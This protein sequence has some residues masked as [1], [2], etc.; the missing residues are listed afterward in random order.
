ML[1][2][3]VGDYL[4][5]IY[6]LQGDGAVSTTDIARAL[7]VSSASVTNMIK[8]LAQMKMVEYESYKGVHLTEAGERIALEIIRHHRLLETYLKEMLGYSWAGMHEEAER[9]EHHISEEFEDKIDALLGHPTH[10]PHG[11]PI[12][13]RDLQITRTATTPLTHAEP[14]QPLVIHHVSDGDAELL[15]YLE[16]IGL[17]PQKTIEI[18]EKAP[19]KG[20]LTLRIGDREQVVGHEVASNV[21]VTES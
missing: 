3:A 12:P 1:S 6:K 7:E 16:E 10:D 14:G 4:K 20:P 9:L 5:A 17:M 18:V 15:Q 21:F 11:H 8:R 13:T 19:F 2:Q